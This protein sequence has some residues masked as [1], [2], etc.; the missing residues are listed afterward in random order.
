[1]VE[2]DLLSFMR[3]AWDLIRGN[4]MIWLLGFFAALSGD[5]LSN[6][7]VGPQLNLLGDGDLLLAYFPISARWQGC[8]C[9]VDCRRRCW[10]RPMS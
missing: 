4:R 5:L 9:W 7:R 2:V 6:I 1:M 8:W 10:R 3:P